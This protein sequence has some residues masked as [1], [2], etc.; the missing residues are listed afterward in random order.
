MVTSKFVWTANRGQTNRTTGSLSSY[1]SNLESIRIGE[2]EVP[3]AVTRL[4]VPSWQTSG[5]QRVIVVFC[6]VCL[7]QRTNGGSFPNIFSSIPLVCVF[8]I[9][10]RLEDTDNK[11]RNGKRREQDAA[12][13]ERVSLSRMLKQLGLGALE[14][15]VVVY[16]YMFTIILSKFSLRD[17][18]KLFCF[19]APPF[20]FYF[21]CTVC[22]SD[23]VHLSRWRFDNERATSDL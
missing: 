22:L 14:F 19:F 11:E 17:H 16:W 8:V 21:N 6:Q 10:L 3:E 4:T 7:T 12:N 5:Q 20:L 18:N 1:S 2:V 15:L 13:I 9:S 23:A